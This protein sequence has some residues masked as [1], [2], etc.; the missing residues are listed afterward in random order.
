[1]EKSRPRECG[2]FGRNRRLHLHS[3]ARDPV[4]DLGD[5]VHGLP[6]SIQLLAYS[7]LAKEHW[8]KQS[9]L[10]PQHRDL[11]RCRCTVARSRFAILA[12]LR[13]VSTS[14]IAWFRQSTRI[15]IAAMR[16]EGTR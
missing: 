4:V 16:H 3:S 15:M 9:Q 11:A 10:R 12:S 13:E 8:R 7:P 14:E 5:G 6:R 2:R 1:M